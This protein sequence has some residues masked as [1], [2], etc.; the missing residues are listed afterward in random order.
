MTQPAP[1]DAPALA[2]CA[3]AT[4]AGTS[5]LYRELRDHPGCSVR[6]VKELHYWDSFAPAIRSRYLGVLS[7]RHAGHEAEAARAEAAGQGPRAASQ[8]RQARDCAD[9]LAVLGG[10]RDGDL[11]YL[12]YLADG[13]GGRLAADLTPSYGLLPDDVL[14]RAVAAVPGARWVYLLRDPVARLWSHVRMEAA[15]GLKG[16]GDL[17]AEAGR[18]LA[19]VLG[20]ARPDILSRGDYPAAVGRLRRAVPEGRLRVEFCDRLF[21]PAGWD[22]MQGFLGLDRHPAR[23]ASPAHEGPQAPLD[24]GLAARALGLLRPHYDWAARAVG[25]LPP[26]WAATLERV[27]A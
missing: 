27:T 14:A 5:W 11:A 13:A 19:Q 22:A 1:P 17:A 3:G 9:L 10:D 2:I 16:A 4:K 15:R 8:R 18:M 26:S 25:P 23:G 7:R 6:A 24:P 20:G 12:A 21:T